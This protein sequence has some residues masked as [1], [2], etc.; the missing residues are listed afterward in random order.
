MPTELAE[1]TLLGL[2]H[3]LLQRNHPHVGLVA[4]GSGDPWAREVREKA[5]R[6]DQARQ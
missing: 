2:D 5:E 3:D 1:S 4:A 6:A